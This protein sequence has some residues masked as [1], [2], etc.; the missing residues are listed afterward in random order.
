MSVSVKVFL[1]HSLRKASFT[2]EEGGGG[3]K[4]KQKKKG[5]LGKEPKDNLVTQKYRT[6]ALIITECVDSSQTQQSW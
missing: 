2:W 5:T 6:T 1:F 4:T 3:K